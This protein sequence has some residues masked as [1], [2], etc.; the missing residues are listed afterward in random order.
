MSYLGKTPETQGGVPLCSVLWFPSRA[1][2]PTGFVALDGQLL[3]RSIYPS[4][5]DEVN[6]GRVPVVSEANWSSDNTQRGA[7]TTGDGSTTF[8]L[9]DFNGKSSGSAGAVFLRGDGTSS[10]GTNGL[11][12]RDAF[13]G[14]NHSIPSS[15]ASNSGTGSARSGASTTVGS[16]VTNVDSGS[17]TSDG[18]NG[19]PRTATETRPLNVTGCFAIKM[20]GIVTA[21]SILDTSNVAAN[22]SALTGRMN[23]NTMFRAITPAGNG[24]TNTRIRRWTTVKSTDPLN[25]QYNASTTLGDSFTILVAGVYSISW[26]DANTAAT[27][28]GLMLND[29]APSSTVGASTADQVLAAMTSSATTGWGMNMSWTGYLDAGAILTCKADN[30]GVNEGVIKSSINITR[31]L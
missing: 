25:V 16:G 6:A 22:V 4:V 11:I 9:P 14:H 10:T 23:R 5:W 13:Q 1:Y 21:Q 19:T 30:A 2:L 18:T 12:Q 26:S 27:A 31:V 29:S 8:R 28:C 24:S 15:Y 7:F 20:F 17:P 3:T